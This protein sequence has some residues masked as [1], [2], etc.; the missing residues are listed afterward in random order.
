MITATLGPNHAAITVNANLDMSQSK[1]VATMYDKPAGTGNATLPT[2]QNNTSEN[3]TQPGA[4]GNQGILGVGTNGATA[5]GTAGNTNYTKTQTQQQN[6]VDSTQT[7]SDI[8]AG[9]LKRL[10]VSAVLDSTVVPTA[11]DV[12]KWTN[13]I[14]AAAG[15]DPARDGANALQVTTVAFDQKAAKAAADKLAAAPVGN[16]LFDLIKHVLTLL[17]I[18]LILF[19]AWKAIKRA[20]ANRMPLRVPL[21]L[22]ELE[23]PGVGALDL[24]PLAAAVASPAGAPTNRTTARVAR[25]RHHRLDRTPTR[26]SGADPALLARRSQSVTT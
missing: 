3:L 18:G 1:S 24:A 25:R 26:R 4:A 8:P 16:P 5:T 2:S 17:M 15:I 11:A 12:T 21:D 22:R 14:Q 23:A 20:E 13:Q 19:F 10:S 7:N 6:A 9:T